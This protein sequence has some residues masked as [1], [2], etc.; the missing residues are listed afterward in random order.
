MAR[1]GYDPE[2]GTDV[3][4]KI[5]KSS[6]HMKTE[7]LDTH[8][9]GPDRLAGWERA[10]NEVRYSSDLMPN[11]ADAEYEPRLQQARAFGDSETNAQVNTVALSPST[12]SSSKESASALTSSVSTANS[13]ENKSLL[14]RT[15]PEV[16]G[17]ALVHDHSSKYVTP[18]W[19]DHSTFR[20]YVD[21]AKRRKFSA[22][23]CA[24]MFGWKSAR[25]EQ[26]SAEAK[27]SKESASALTSS[28][29][30]AS[31]WESKRILGRTD[32]EVCGFALGQGSKHETPRWETDSFFRK[33]VDE[34]KRRGFSAHS[35]AALFG[36]ESSR[37]KQVSAEATN[38]EKP[39]EID[40]PQT[41]AKLAGATT[42]HASKD[43]VFAF[44]EFGG[45]GDW[46]EIPRQVDLKLVLQ[47]GDWGIFEYA[48]SGGGVG[49]GWINMDIVEPYK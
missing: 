49:Q 47:K 42:W 9:A 14:S 28:A 21:E 37:T 4:I 6:G 22:H 16:C 27:S 5:T 48:A 1:A 46:I 23:S 44:S 2:A 29:S 39:T 41:Q 34:A 11:F 36:W 24:A 17:V 25:T 33:Y 20:T 40:D 3:W 43:R 31:S 10:V 26:V 19:E 8:P 35:C 45:K 32:P 18:R 7:L 38:I 30:T 12:S 13:S 15:D